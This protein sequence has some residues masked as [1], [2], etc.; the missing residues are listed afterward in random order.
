MIKISGEIFVEQKH[1]N[2]RGVSTQQIKLWSK[3]GVFAKN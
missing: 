1:L 3:S 2:N